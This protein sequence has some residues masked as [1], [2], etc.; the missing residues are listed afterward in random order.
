MRFSHQFVFVAA[1]SIQLFLGVNIAADEVDLDFA[2]IAQS[3]RSDTYPT[4]SGPVNLLQVFLE[5]NSLRNRLRK[6]KI[7][8]PANAKKHANEWYIGTVGASLH[9]DEVL[10]VTMLY[11]W[12]GKNYAWC[13]SILRFDSRAQYP[14]V[15]NRLWINAMNGE[16]TP[17]V[18][19]SSRFPSTDDNTS[20]GPRGNLLQVLA[21]SQ[22]VADQLKKKL[23]NSKVPYPESVRELEKLC[24]ASAAPVL[25]RVKVAGLFALGCTVKDFGR[26]SDLIWIVHKAVNFGSFHEETW[27]NSRN[28]KSLSIST[29]AWQAPAEP[30]DSN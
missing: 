19:R 5:S 21:E 26:D 29:E 24:A 7:K 12:G 2:S 8:D 4:P 27:L 14:R 23:R 25:G 22:D 6:C 10:S 13:V 16:I 9:V 28:G 1:I 15:C 17:V 11:V 30:T 20:L 18:P 3:G